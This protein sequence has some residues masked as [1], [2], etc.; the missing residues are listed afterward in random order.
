[1]R[2]DLSLMAPFAAL[3]F[4]VSFVIALTA[5]LGVA[6]YQ[7]ETRKQAFRDKCEADGGVFI[8]TERPRQWLCLNPS[9]VRRAS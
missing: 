7:G 5:T 4:V 6:A 9:S 3:S 1:M 2:P 8:Q